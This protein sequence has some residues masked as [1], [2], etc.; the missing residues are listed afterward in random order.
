MS[1]REF[2]GVSCDICHELREYK[3]YK[4]AEKDGHIKRCPKC[5][6]LKIK[7]WASY[8]PTLGHYVALICSDCK[9]LWA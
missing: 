6:G 3:K 2:L 8:T 5:G 9:H 4:D 7:M 1:S